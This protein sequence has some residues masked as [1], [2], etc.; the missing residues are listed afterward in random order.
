MGTT[1]LIADDAEWSAVTL[2]VLALTLP[3]VSVVRAGNG[4]EAWRLTE[5]RPVSII[6]TDLRMPR[7][8]GFEL[9]ERVRAR[10]TEANIP[11]IVVTADDAPETQ[12][13]AQR[14]GANAFFVK[15]YS[16]AKVRETLKELLNDTQP[17][18]PL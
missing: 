1:V 2:E 18:A 10:A 11:I 3:D 5:E 16:P 12:R 13:R 14:L 7:M 9:I 4:Q 6:I 17:D 8:D 15:P